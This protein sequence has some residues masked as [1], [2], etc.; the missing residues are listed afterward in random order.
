MQENL[1]SRY[2]GAGV[3]E[4]ISRGK[5][6]REKVEGQEEIAMGSGS[7][8]SSLM[9]VELCLFVVAFVSCKGG[10]TVL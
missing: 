8:L 7:T 9:L 5:R 4:E 1:W 2:R 10:P 3:G 6:K